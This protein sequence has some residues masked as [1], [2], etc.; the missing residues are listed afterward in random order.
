MGPRGPGGCNPRGGVESSILLGF[1]SMRSLRQDAR[2]RMS[3]R[4][5]GHL[6]GPASDR[7]PT[8]QGRY[9]SDSNRDVARTEREK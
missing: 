5:D 7:S 4:R 1:L 3:D 2:C 9:S 6:R 8:I